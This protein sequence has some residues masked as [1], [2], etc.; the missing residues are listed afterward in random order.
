MDEFQK[1][2]DEAMAHLVRLMDRQSDLVAVVL[3]VKETNARLA[4][5]HI[6]IEALTKQVVENNIRLSRILEVHDYGIDELDARL[7]RLE[8]RRRPE[9]RT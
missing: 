5:R 8:E 3:Q 6:D 1:R 4:E 7:R 2:W 9:Q